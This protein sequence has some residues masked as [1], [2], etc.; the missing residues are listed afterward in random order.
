[1]GWTSPRTWVTGETVTAAMLNEQLRD[2]FLYLGD[3]PLNIDGGL[4]YTDAV[5]DRVGIGTTEPRE[6]L[7]INGNIRIATNR[8][9]KGGG[10][11]DCQQFYVERDDLTL[12]TNVGVWAAANM[13]ILSFDSNNSGVGELR[14]GKGTTTPGGANW[15]DFLTIDN[16]GNVGI[17]T[18]SPQVTLE[19][20]GILRVLN[21]PFYPASG[22]GLEIIYDQDG[23]TAYIQS[24][25]RDTSS[26][27]PL[28]IRGN[29]IILEKG[30]VGIGT[31]SPVAMLHVSGFDAGTKGTLHIDAA[32]GENAEISLVTAAPGNNAWIYLDE[33]DSQKLKIVA[34]DAATDT[35]GIFLQQDGNVGIGTMSPSEKLE[36]AGDVKLTDDDPYLILNNTET[37]VAVPMIIGTIDFWGKNAAGTSLELA[38]IDARIIGDVAGSESAR[39]AFLGKIGGADNLA[40]YFDMDGSGYADVG[41][42]TFSPDI[43]DDASPKEYLEIA[44]EDALKPKKPFRGL[45]AAPEELKNYEKDIA[46]IAIAIARYCE[47][48]E[49]R[50]QRIEKHLGIT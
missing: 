48:V 11:P 9:I 20:N 34:G 10:Y 50:L 41:W 17:G 25:D 23:A 5:N 33:S 27:R 8:A 47:G 45:D 21:D 40:F 39:L 6:K 2:N 14:I 49:A 22:H 19:V 36:V 13:L 30:S 4:L 1:M 32:A 12:G 18:T 3:P 44:L 43:P 28:Y 7:H 42:Y 24:Y 35:T 29:N 46:K 38:K 26:W 15:V 16:D 31:P 37:P